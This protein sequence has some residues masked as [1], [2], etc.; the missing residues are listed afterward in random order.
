MEPITIVMNLEM[1]HHVQHGCALAAG[2]ERQGLRT[3]AQGTHQGIHTK[4]VAC[5]GWRIGQQLHKAGHDVLVMER[6]YLGDREAWTSLVWNGLNNN[7][8]WPKVPNDHTR[9]LKNHPH[10]QIYPNRIKDEGH[11]GLIIG[12]VP[13]DMSLRGM[14]LQ[15]W[16]EA[17]ARELAAVGLKA[18]F[19]PH[20]K[21]MVKE[22]LDESLFWV[23]SR[24]N[25]LLHVALENTETV[26]TFNSTTAVESILRGVN[27]VVEDSTSVA[28]G[29]G[30]PSISKRMSIGGR[31]QWLSELAWK[32]WSIEELKS[33]SVWDVIGLDRFH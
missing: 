3:Y 13:G 28:W 31:L 11:Y 1:P 7:G 16:Y 8:Q 19:R 17:K 20:P 25:Q 29:M 10:L 5:W 33:G 23:I 22:P 2:L 6:G 9:L 12:Q 18:V 21:T 32:Q 15:P 26:V 14:S 30:S 24:P 4:H 27:T